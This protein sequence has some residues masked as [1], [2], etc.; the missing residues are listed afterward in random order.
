MMPFAMIAVLGCTSP[1]LAGPAAAQEVAGEVGAAQVGGQ[2]VVKAYGIST[3]ND[4][5]YPA[6]FQHLDYVN[7]EAPK[8]GEMSEWTVG[9]FDNFNPYSVQGRAAALASVPQESILTGTSDT[10]GQSYCLMCTTLEYPV[11]KDWVIFHLRE[12]ITF[13]DGTPMTAQD[14]LFS[15]EQLRDYGLSSFR[16]LVAQQVASAEVLDDHTIKYTF[17]KDAPRRD[18]IQMVG[19][20]PVFEQKQFERLNLTLDKTFPEALVGT[21]PYMYDSD[22]NNRSITWKRNPDYWGK[23]L[24]INRGR[25]NFDKLRI[26]YFGD[27]NAAFEAFKVGIYRFRNEASSNSWATGY[28]FP[29]VKS[30]AVVKA[31]LPDGN[32]ASGQAFVLNMRRPMFQDPK[33]REAVGLAFNFEWSNKTLFHGLYERVNSIWENSPLEATGKPSPEELKILEPLKAD[34]PEGVL[35]EDAVMAPVSGERAL[36][37]KNLRQAAKLLE[38]AGWTVGSDGL[39]RKDGK[40]LH[41]DILNDSQSMDRV[42]NPYVENLKQLG[43]E[44]VNERVDDAQY[45][46]RER[47]HDFDMVISHFGQDLL[48]GSDLQQY[49]GSQSVGDVFNAMGLA[50]PAVDKLIT[51]VEQATTEDE[52]TTRVHALDRVLRAIRFWV[53]QWYKNTYTVAYYDIFDHPQTLPPYSLGEMDFWW[54]DAAKAEKLKA[55]GAL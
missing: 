47:S 26:E 27:Y 12:G 35:T 44:A 52:L 8:G 45:Q 15:F 16:Q 49:F 42:I 1:L 14:V 50:N 2:T 11:S 9:A 29:A 21:G 28:T 39:R 20:L 10:V 48:P 4:L 22:K 30:G 18:V 34:L 55:S 17:T 25:N 24:P 23:D 6:D 19:G 5:K 13:S 38:E 36:D 7:P 43:I 40:V 31:E 51:L 54:Y 41:I 33:V 37:R 32:V 3:L 53:P 46:S